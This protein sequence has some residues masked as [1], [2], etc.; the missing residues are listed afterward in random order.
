LTV[1]GFGDAL[2][3]YY[4]ARAC[5]KSGAASPAG[6]Q[7]TMAA[8]ALAKLCLDT[9]L[10]EGL[11]AKLALEAKAC[12]ESVEKVIEANTLLSGIGFESV[13]TAAAHAIQTGFNALAECHNM[14]HGEKVAFG[15]IAQ[16]VLENESFETIEKIIRFCISVGLPVTLKEL[17]IKDVTEEKLKTI[18]KAACD[19]KESIH[20]MPFKVTEEA[21][22]S[23]IK[24][25]DNYGKSFL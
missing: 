17:G 2:A 9:L 19:E 5:Y 8:M 14:Y 25:A 23:A 1:S 16:L 12:T 20:N 21:I 7:S 18:A 22:I 6:G 10:E 11:K 4:E 15:T 3:T 24:A 13:G